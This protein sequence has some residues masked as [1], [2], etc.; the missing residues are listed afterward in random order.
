MAMSRDRGT[1]RQARDFGYGA[2]CDLDGRPIGELAFGDA[3]QEHG[4]LQ[5]TGER[6]A[7]LAQRFPLGTQLRILPNHACATGAQFDR[8]AVIGASGGGLQD[9]PRFGGW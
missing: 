1:Q 6:G 5:W 3:N 4:V 2:V 7:D 9:W 8:Y